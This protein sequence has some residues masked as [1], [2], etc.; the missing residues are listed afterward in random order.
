MWRKRR[1]LSGPSVATLNPN[2]GIDEIGIPNQMLWDIYK[3]F[4]IRELITM[5]LTPASAAKQYKDRSAL[6]DRALDEAIKNRPIFMN[7][8]PS[9]HKHS[10]M[11]F[12]PRRTNEI[13]IQANPL[14]FSGYNLDFDGD[15]VM[16]YPPVTTEA[17]EEAWNAL[18][19]RN[20]YKSGTKSV[21]HGHTWDYKIG[22]YYATKKGNKTGLKFKSIEDARR[23]RPALKYNDVF[24]LDGK[25]MTLGLWEANEPLPNELKDYDRAIDAKT[26]E[27]LLEQLV[28]KHPNNFVDSIN[29]WKDLGYQTAFVRGQTLSIKD[30]TYDRSLRDALV[31]EAVKLADKHP[32]KLLPIMTQAEQEIEKYQNERLEKDKNNA[33]DFVESKALSGAKGKNITQVLSMVGIV[34]DLKGNPI[35]VPITKSWAEG[36]DPFDY[37]SSLYGARKG[38]VDRSINTADTGFLNKVL[39][40]NTARVVITEEDCETPK[41]IEETQLQP[42]HIIG[43]VLAKDIP[44][45]GRKGEVIDSKMLNL[46]KKYNILKVPVRSPLTCEAKDNGICQLCYGWTTSG[47]FPMVGENVGIT[48]SQSITEPLTQDTMK[49]FHTGGKVG[50][51]N[52]AQGFERANEIL[53]M[54]QNLMGI[55]TLATVGGTVTSIVPNPAGGYNV[56]VEDKLHYVPIGRELKVKRGDRVAP[57]DP[58]SDGVYR[59]QDLVELKGAG[60]AREYMVNELQHT[61]LDPNKIAKRTVET[62]VKGITDRVE[63]VDPKDDETFVKGDLAFENHINRVNRGREHQ[64]PDP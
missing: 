46:I 38:S 63:V 52:A 47:K 14:I 55:G 16:I 24:E 45:V 33:W 53:R 4:I 23:Y 50:V 61:F 32:D 35:P 34:A 36:Q 31:S 43:R 59:P 54:K 1:D 19:S 9:L 7:R 3:P 5:G 27:K 60:P 2:L 22:L 29:K 37:W 57:G 44:N 49:T 25:D 20:P 64:S 18:P 26:Y 21:I 12:K 48:D 13:S 62:V 28:E 17:V 6:A 58:L 11:S 40:N 8:A 42:I 51:A 30:M 15:Q 39:L 41:F 10:V 56:K